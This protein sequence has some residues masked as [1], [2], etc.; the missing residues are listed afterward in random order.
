MLKINKQLNREIAAHKL[1]EKALLNSEERYRSL[2]NDV[3]DTSAVGIFILDAD[4]KIVWINQ[5]IEHFFGLR[6]DVVIGKDKR[7]I[8]QNQIK[9][10]FED[11]ETFREKVFATYDNN[12]YIENF[13]CHV[14][15]GIK[16]NE[17][18]LEHISQP[19]R[20]GVRSHINPS[21]SLRLIKTI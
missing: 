16:R 11:P 6:R 12:T 20:S 7:P 13:E 1:T 2:T 19:I 18:W 5:A 3:M 17:R 4:F 15:P 21:K 14:L 8:I 9:N 10:I